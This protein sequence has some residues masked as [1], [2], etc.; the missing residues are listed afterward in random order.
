MS[1]GSDYIVHGSALSSTSSGA[2]N[3]CN[4]QIRL[5]LLHFLSTPIGVRLKPNQPLIFG[6]ARRGSELQ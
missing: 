4:L 6:A 2:G 3:A 1:F 5:D